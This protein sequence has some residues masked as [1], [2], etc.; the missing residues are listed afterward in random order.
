M[1]L[2]NTMYCYI[3]VSRF[4][5]SDLFGICIN[6]ESVQLI[7]KACIFKAEIYFYVK[8]VNI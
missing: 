7:F 3:E 2:Y 8:T 6:N 5:Y 4:S 1:Q